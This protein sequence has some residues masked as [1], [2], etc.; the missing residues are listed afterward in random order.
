MIHICIY[1]KKNWFCKYQYL[2]V[3]F[4]EENMNVIHICFIFEHILNNMDT[5]LILFVVLAVHKKYGYKFYF[6]I[7]ICSGLYISFLEADM[8]INIAKFLSTFNL[9]TTHNIKQTGKKTIHKSLKCT[10]KPIQVHAYMQRYKYIGR[11]RDWDGLW[12]KP[13]NK[14]PRFS[15]IEYML[16]CSWFTVLDTENNKLYVLEVSYPC[17]N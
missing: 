13:V 9:L 16:Q 15:W 2:Y 3:H 12:F 11:H 8:N 17:T 10:Y 5:S 7:D 6:L 4:F 14:N 1:L